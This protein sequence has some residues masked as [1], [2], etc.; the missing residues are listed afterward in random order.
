MKNGA[1]K[2]KMLDDGMDGMLVI[3]KLP[4]ETDKM[5]QFKRQQIMHDKVSAAKKPSG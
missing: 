2:A 3:D 1:D 5:I 4:P